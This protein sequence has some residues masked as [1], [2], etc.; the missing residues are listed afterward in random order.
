MYK[1]RYELT[2]DK[3]FASSI[4]NNPDQIITYQ[5]KIN[6][7]YK[8]FMDRVYR[9]A[10][11]L[12][13]LGLKK[14][15][16]V[17]VLDWDTLPYMEAYYAVPLAGGVLHTVNI[18]YPEELLY[19]SM[20]HAEDKFVI[21]RDEFIPLI[22]KRLSAFDFINKWIVASDHAEPLKTIPGSVRFN[23]LEKTSDDIEL[24]ELKEDDIATTFYTSGTTGLPKGV[25][26]THRQ[27]ML[28]GLSVALGL[29]K[30]P[31]LLKT[32]DV[33]LPLVP[34]FHV[35]SWGSPYITIMS[36]QKY[37]LPGRYDFDYIPTIMEKE[38]VTFSEMVPSILYML[39]TGKGKDL[40]R[41]LNLKVSIG[42][43]ALTEGLEKM[44]IASN[45]TVVGGY[46]MSETAPV[47]TLSN[48]NK[49]V[50]EQ[51]VEARRQ[52][53]RKTGLPIPL[54]DLRVVD[55]SM[56]EVAHNS[57]AIGE[58]V[59]RA[60]WLTRAYVKDETNSAKLW[61]DDWMHT[62]D[63][64]MVDEL[65]YV[66]IVDRE[67]DA[68]KSGGEFIPSLILEE[69][70]STFPGVGEVAVVGK[71]DEKWGER[72]VAFFT[73]NGAVIDQGKLVD[74]LNNYANTGRISKF[75]IPD[76]FVTIKEF[77]KTSTGKIDKKPLIE[78]VRSK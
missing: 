74:H 1:D 9:V 3:I 31:F 72:P 18:R 6:V 30:E 67:K 47:L 11:G 34:M 32:T 54:V 70:I 10:R 66:S 64:A 24:P 8:E 37:V 58:I 44:A 53:H 41:N 15:D 62:G 75:W 73:T 16:R 17:A 7:T 56:K 42:G 36:G 51:P 65:G 21:V 14:G 68:I 77:T 71:P 29:S 28:H 19:Y 59:V 78:K 27:I 57:K 60:P 50:L 49:K 4:R 46:G 13:K 45:I 48:Y 22:E 20:Q 39:L 38:G 12:I 5:G 76:E 23:S 61:K 69:A 35:H 55:S 63:L 25:F 40:L 52:Y 33:I 2:I 26:F 43:S